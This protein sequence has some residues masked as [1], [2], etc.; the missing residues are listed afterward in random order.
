MNRGN[1]MVLG[2]P[3]DYMTYVAS[4]TAHIMLKSVCNICD[5][6][7]SHYKRMSLYMCMHVVHLL[8]LLAFIFAVSYTVVIFL[9]ISIAY[10]NCKFLIDNIIHVNYSIIDAA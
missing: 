4:Q 7:L 9:L 1:P 8:H 3:N 5:N 10:L 2:N 6:H